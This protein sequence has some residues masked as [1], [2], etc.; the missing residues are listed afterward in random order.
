MSRLVATTESDYKS[1]N[2]TLFQIM[3]PR[4]SGTKGNEDVRL[5]IIDY[6][7]KLNWFVEEDS[8]HDRTP[9]GMKPFTN[10]IATHNPD[11]C[12][13]VVLSC[14]YD[15]KYFS[16]F[17]FVGATDSAVPCTMI[18]E[19]VRILNEKLHRH[20][21]SY[22]LFWNT[23]TI[24]IQFFCIEQRTYLT[25]NVFRWRGSI[26]RLDIDRFFVRFSTFGI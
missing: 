9:F 10:I 23:D 14:H 3:V 1:F 16:D 15:S 5:Y 6:L 12:K 24:L 17:E 25:T 2:E 13:R 7:R 4:V 11:A 26:Q 21:V 18:L 8:F 19:L 20:K 22:E